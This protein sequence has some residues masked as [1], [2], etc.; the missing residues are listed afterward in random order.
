MEEYFSL[1]QFTIFSIYFNEYYCLQFPFTFP[2]SCSLSSDFIYVLLYAIRSFI[3]YNSIYSTI[4]YSER[5][6]WLWNNEITD[7]GII[8]F[9]LV[10]LLLP[11]TLLLCILELDRMRSG[12]DWFSNTYYSMFNIYT[13]NNHIDFL[14]AYMKQITYIIW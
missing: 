2:I 13:S 11:S 12:L 10:F 14:F 5:F 8:R 4:S 1:L 9:A 6:L 7:S 3:H